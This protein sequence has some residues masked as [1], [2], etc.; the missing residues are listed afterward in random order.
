[1][2]SMPIAMSAFLSTPSARRATCP[3]VFVISSSLYFYPRPPRGGRHGHFSQLPS[4]CL[5]LSTPSA[6]RATSCALPLCLLVRYFYPRPPRG[7][8]QRVADHSARPR[9]ISIHALREEGD[10]KAGARNRRTSYFYPRPPRGGRRSCSLH[11]RRGGDFYPRPP[12]GGRREEIYAK[13]K[14]QLFLS[15]PSARRATRFRVC[16]L[17]QFRISIHALREEGDAL[18]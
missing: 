14:I 4:Q 18:L 8:R 16:L 5:F 12:R 7:G 11:R 3:T 10:A 17:P 9:H 6:R 15:T 1:M 2:M 13:D